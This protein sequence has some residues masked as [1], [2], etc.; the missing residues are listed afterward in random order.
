MSLP[1]S[2]A[3]GCGRTVPY[4]RVNP[5]RTLAACEVVNEGRVIGSRCAAYFDMSSNGDFRRVAQVKHHRFAPLGAGQL[6]FHL[7][8]KLYQHTSVII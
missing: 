5:L 6:L 7:L 2:N 1:I 8:S 4:Q 3:S